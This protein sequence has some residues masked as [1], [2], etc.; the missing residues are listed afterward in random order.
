[1]KS[2]VNEKSQIHPELKTPQNENYLEC[3]EVDLFQNVFHLEY[4]LGDS[5]NM[6][7]NI[8]CLYLY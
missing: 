8:K 3:L 1:M 2:S 6:A 7:L 4:K 5:I